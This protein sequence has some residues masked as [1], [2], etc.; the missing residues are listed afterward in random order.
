MTHRSKVSEEDRSPE[1]F[2]A[3]E[4]TARIASGGL[5][6]VALAAKQALLLDPAAPV[7]VFDRETG[8]VV[9]LDLRGAELEVVARYTPEPIS[10]P[11]RG[12]PKLGVIAREITLLP[13]HWDWLSRQPGGASI[14]LRRLVEAARKADGGATKSRERIDAAYRFMSAM[15]GDFPGF[16]DAARA[17]FAN[18]RNGGLAAAIS[19][20]PLDIREEV[21]RFLGDVSCEGAKL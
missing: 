10:T 9:D 11:A 7:I 20:W 15:A 4:G 17:L 1:H 18:D 12:R 13:R 21:L 14:T 5:A 19:Q 8:K 2:V 6:H 3:F 16:E